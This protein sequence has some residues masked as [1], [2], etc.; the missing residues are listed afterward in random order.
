MKRYALALLLH[1]YKTGIVPRSQ[2][3]AATSH[4]I[5]TLCLVLQRFPQMRFNL[6]LPGYILEAADPLLSARLRDLCKRSLLEMI[7]TGYTEPFLSLSP[8]DLTVKNI[9]HG[10]KV[11]EEHTGQT[12]RGFL[13]PFSNWEPSFIEHLRNSGFRYSLLSNE[14]F[15]PETQCVPGYWV[16]EHT[17]TSIG[18]IGT[19]ILGTSAI[20]NNFIDSIRSLFANETEAIQEPFAVMH[21]LLSLQPDK[22]EESCA[23]IM[24]M[25][26]AIDKN[27]LQ[28]QPVCIGD[29]LSTIHPVGMQYI[30]AS[31]QTQRFGTVD[32]HFMNFLFS[33]DQIGFLQRKVLDIFDRLTGY[34]SD[35]K[36][37]PLLHELFFAQ[38]INRFLPGKEAGFEVASDR[39][40]T[41]RHIIGIDAKLRE[42]SG[43]SGV[44]TRITDFL[45]NGGKTII[46]SN[47]SLKLFI[48]P[49]CGGQITGLDFRPRQINLCGM[50]NPVRR[51]LP[52]IIVSGSSRTWFLDRI[53]QEPNTTPDSAAHLFSD[54][55]TLHRGSMNYK[56]RK[57]GEGITIS[58]LQAG[59]FLT[60]DKLQPLSL[61]KVFGIENEHPELSFVY[62]FSNPSLMPY[63]F[64]FA[65]ELNMFLPGF[66]RGAGE[67]F[68]G[69]SHYSPTNNQL[70]H[71]PDLTSWHL[72][73]HYS[74]VRITFHLQ[75]PMSLW[76]PAPPAGAASEGVPMILT[77]AVAMEPSSRFKIVGKITF[78]SI[79]AEA[80]ID[81]AL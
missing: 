7:C 18:L 21:Y 45:H 13:P 39:F 16:A 81:D 61:E 40:D 65:T 1:P 10:I 37:T 35:K 78:K 48:D 46:L 70:L 25:A 53:V 47:K 58:L 50:Y 29:F 54:I 42:L 36:A 32:L 56:I 11:I 72:D 2:L 14:L 4:L 9:M 26:E 15:S 19:N 62:Q 63:R 22:L 59:S 79:K 3:R 20:H 5:E 68:A 28:Y 57:N 30:P 51:K 60:E 52:D 77:A 67:I 17:G 27:L 33:F 64:E 66:S 69:K 76:F 80:G 6:V 44:R 75:K 74:G 12:P 71:L 49:Q 31:L 34:L 55:S 41:Y 73:D 38:D 8:T 23:T 24:H 43:N